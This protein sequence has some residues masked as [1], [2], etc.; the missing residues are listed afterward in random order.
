[1]NNRDE[2]RHTMN[3]KKLIIA[4]LVC[5]PM[6]GMAQDNVWEV[7]DASKQQE[8]AKT[9][10]KALIEKKTVD[11]KYLA[12]AVPE[13]NGKV[14]FTLD[15]DVPGMSAEDIYQKVYSVMQELVEETKD[16][17][18]D[19]SSR[20]VAVNKSEHTIVAN[21]REWLVFSSSFLQL[22]RTQMNYILVARATDHHINVTM[23]RIN[24][25]YEIHRENQGLRTSAE[26]WISD[27]NGLNK[28]KTKM[29]KGSGKFRI[30]TIDRKDN[31]FSRIDK[32]LGI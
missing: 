19:P 4:L 1:M 27:E 9:P 26:E 32:A 25:A 22:D 10:R 7:P 29:A 16:K 18:I 6:V 14:V 12:G 3:R 21:M 13:V 24:Y 8:Q 28:K 30:K 5:L 11:K 2:I 23:E 31:I 17:E 15:K 20:I